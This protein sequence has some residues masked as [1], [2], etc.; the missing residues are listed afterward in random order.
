[1]SK[2]LKEIIDEEDRLLKERSSQQRSEDRL[3]FLSVPLLCVLAALFLSYWAWNEIRN[4]FQVWGI[5]VV[6]QLATEI[7]ERN[8]R[9]IL[10]KS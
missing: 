10:V 7:A 1:V 2:A 9:V 4:H 3:M 6:K 5:C 8:Y